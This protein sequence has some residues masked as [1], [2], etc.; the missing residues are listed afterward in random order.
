MRLNL[1]LKNPQ[2]GRLT[3]ALYNIWKQN[4]A[5][6]NN[7]LLEALTKKM[8]QGKSMRIKQSPKITGKLHVTNILQ[9]IK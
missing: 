2:V 6:T 5:L 1:E 8:N 4:N 3:Y 7:Q 9:P